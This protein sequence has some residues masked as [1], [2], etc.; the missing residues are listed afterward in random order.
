M[1]ERLSESWRTVPHFFLLR[2]VEATRMLAWR[3]SLRRRAGYEPSP[4]PTCWSRSP[5]LRSAR[6]HV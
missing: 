2:Q 6:T 4:T 1:A 3:E 5:P